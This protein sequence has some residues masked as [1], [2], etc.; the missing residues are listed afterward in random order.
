VVSC[1]G[2]WGDCSIEVKVVI[3]T[4]VHRDSSVSGSS[5]GY[6]LQSDSDHE[7]SKCL[8]VC[9]CHWTDACKLVTSRTLTAYANSNLS[10]SSYFSN[11]KGSV[12]HCTAM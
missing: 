9:S 6:P 2:L 10:S 1:S 8:D 12:R 3:V 7:H 4:Y 11:V 5:R